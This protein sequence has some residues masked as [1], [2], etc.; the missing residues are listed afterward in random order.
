RIKIEVSGDLNGDDEFSVVDA[1][2]LQKWLLRSDQVEIYYLE[3]GDLDLN[4]K[5]D[6]FDLAIM[7]LMLVQGE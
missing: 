6:A 4:G 5:L 2:A 7:K 3:E 1:I